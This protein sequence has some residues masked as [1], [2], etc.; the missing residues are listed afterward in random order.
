MQTQLSGLLGYLFSPVT[1]GYAFLKDSAVGLWEP[2]CTLTEADVDGYIDLSFLINRIPYRIRF[3][4]KFGPPLY[5]RIEKED[6]VSV[7][8]EVARFAGPCRNFYGIPTT[9]RMLGF[10][11]LK[12]IFRD[13]E[14]ET[15][16]EHQLIILEK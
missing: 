4:R 1:Y 6:G 9:P 13:D 5:K 12:I 15:F 8:N 2:P 10:Q 11:S 14:A 7:T 16:S 3:P